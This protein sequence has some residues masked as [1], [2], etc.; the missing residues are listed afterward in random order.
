[1]RRVVHQEVLGHPAVASDGSGPARM[2]EAGIAG[3]R[4]GMSPQT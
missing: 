1:M 2:L 4:R 3:T